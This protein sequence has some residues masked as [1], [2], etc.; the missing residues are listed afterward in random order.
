[1][2]NLI[3]V[4]VATGGLPQRLPLQVTK[5]F[6]SPAVELVTVHWQTRRES[7]KQANRLTR[8]NHESM[9][10]KLILIALCVWLVLSDILIDPGESFNIRRQRRRRRRRGRRRAGKKRDFISPD[11]K[12]KRAIA[13]NVWVCC[14]S[15]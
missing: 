2:R 3:S 9:D 12:E 7:R 8:K 11:A 14:L 5:Q 6:C 15:V 13:S 1:M 4:N 10:A